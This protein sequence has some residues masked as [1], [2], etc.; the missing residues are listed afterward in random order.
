LMLRGTGDG[1]FMPVDME[2][3]NLVIEGQA[4]DMK[5]VRGANGQRLIVV[6]RNNDKLEIL[7]VTP[8][9]KRG[10]QINPRN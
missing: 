7:R 4:R 9:H 2:E 1:H 3:S 5:P 10:V 8:L 6:A